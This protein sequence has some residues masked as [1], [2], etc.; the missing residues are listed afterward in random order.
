MGHF[1]DDSF[2]KDF[3]YVDEGENMSRGG[4]EGKG[5]GEADSALSK[6]LNAWLDPGT[7]GS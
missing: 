5:E 4:A 6:E 3:I 2:F 1:G 7:P